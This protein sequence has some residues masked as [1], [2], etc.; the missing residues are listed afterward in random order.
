M[1]L[2][3]GMAS[4]KSPNLLPALFLAA[5]ALTATAE[6]PLEEQR[7]ALG[8]RNLTNGGAN[9]VS[10]RLPKREVTIVYLTAVSAPRQWTAA[11]GRKMVGRLMAFPPPKSGQQ[12]P[13]EV[14]RDGKVSLMRSGTKKPVEFPLEKLSAEDQKM[15]KAIA[16]AVK[17]SAQNAKSAEKDAKTADDEPK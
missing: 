1:A 2:N 11:D 17:K 7:K 5:F 13:L 10:P 15:V 12:G 9:V 3:C 4:Q 6:D 14:I 16:E 8:E